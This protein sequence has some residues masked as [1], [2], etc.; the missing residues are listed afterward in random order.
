MGLPTITHLQAAVI[1]SAHRESSGQFI[2]DRL[3]GL[4][5]DHE[6]PIFYRLMQRM[7]KEGLVSGRYVKRMEGSQI[8]RERY[9]KTTAVGRK[10]LEK[11]CEF[12]KEIDG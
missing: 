5:I 6:G 9:Y 8:K 7:E 11:A 2:R 12:Y 3:A 10:L 1:S 4:G